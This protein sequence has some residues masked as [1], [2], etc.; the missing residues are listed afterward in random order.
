MIKKVL[1]IFPLVLFGLGWGVNNSVTS[2]SAPA[3]TSGAPGEV[4]CTTSGCH[5]SFVTNSGPG[6]V[7]INFDNGATTYIPGKTYTINVEVDQSSLI[8]FGFQMVALKNSDN[9]NIGTFIPTD[10][11]RN[12]VTTGYG[13]LSDRKYITY[14]FKSTSSTVAGKGTWT[15]NWTAPANDEGS[16]TFYIASIAA[17]NDGNDLGDYCYTSSLKINSNAPP[18]NPADFSINIFPNPA[19]DNINVNYSITETSQVTIDLIDLQ[20]KVVEQL[21]DAVQNEGEYKLSLPFTNLYKGGAYFVRFDCNEKT[22]FK[23]LFITD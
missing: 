6:S 8:R 11:S 18:I 12:Q 5:Q 7:T 2:N 1:F 21:F 13:N 10:A 20:G 15:F 22:T 16:I 3:S 9:T 23:K 4:N 14:T 19:K 17:N